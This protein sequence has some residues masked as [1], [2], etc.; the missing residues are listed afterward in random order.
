MIPYHRT[1]RGSFTYKISLAV[2]NSMSNYTAKMQKKWCQTHGEEQYYKENLKK[3]HG[4]NLNCPFMRYSRGFGFM[5]RITSYQ[6]HWERA[7]QLSI[8]C[9]EPKL[10]FSWTGKKCGILLMPLYNISVFIYF[11][12]QQSQDKLLNNSRERE[13]LERSKQY[14]ATRHFIDWEDYGNIGHFYVSSKLS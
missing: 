5:S 13:S 6:D 10:T 4:Y 14:S 1:K 11:L 7:D 9:K 2:A 8:K 12:K 3:I